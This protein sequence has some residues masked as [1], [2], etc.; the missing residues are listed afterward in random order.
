[1]KKSEYAIAT[2]LGA[3]VAASAV[4]GCAAT[5]AGPAS[6]SLVSYP[7]LA[8]RPACDASREL[9]VSMT[10]AEQVIAV[11]ANGT[12]LVVAATGPTGATGATGV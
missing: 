1:M 7:S 6:H 9:E 3:L 8:E 2:V 5:E 12:W 4:P 11:C 10:L